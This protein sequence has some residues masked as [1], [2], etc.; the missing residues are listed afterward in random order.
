MSK[1]KTGWLYKSEYGQKL[2][3]STAREKQAKNGNPPGFASK[4]K[5]KALPP[6]M[7]GFGY[8]GKTTQLNNGK[9]VPQKKSER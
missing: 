3:Q 6:T 2:K 9:I 7:S 1:T 5:G 8:T 4:A